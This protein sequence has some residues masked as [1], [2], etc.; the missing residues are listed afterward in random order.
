VEVS[1]GGGW[2]QWCRAATSAAP[3]ALALRRRGGRVRARRARELGAAT[4][5][6][7][8]LP[9][10]GTHAKIGGASRKGRGLPLPMG[11]S[12]PG[13]AGAGAGRAFGL[14]PNREDRI[15]VFLISRIHFLVQR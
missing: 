1:A 8:E 6:G 10:C 5:K 2:P 11:L 14:G 7:A 15:L 9:G 4:L 13:W 12:G 3:A